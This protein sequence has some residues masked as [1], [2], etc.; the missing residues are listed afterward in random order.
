MPLKLRVIRQHPGGQLAR[1]GDEVPIFGDAHQAQARTPAGL[2]APQH[3]ALLPQL[4]VLLRELEPIESG[5]HGLNPLA[6]QRP[7]FCRRDEEAQARHAATPHPPSQL[8]QLGHPE[9]VGVEHHHG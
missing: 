2:R 7:L 4:E 3:V 1:L 5:C 9:P 6:S 8:V